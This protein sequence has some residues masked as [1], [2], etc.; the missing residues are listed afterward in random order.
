MGSRFAI[1]ETHVLS[2]RHN[3]YD[4]AADF[5]ADDKAEVLNLP[6]LHHLWD[7]HRLHSKNF[8]SQESSA[9]WVNSQL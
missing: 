4:D 2:A 6:H 8:R 3:M 5:G 9:F 7:L 1:S